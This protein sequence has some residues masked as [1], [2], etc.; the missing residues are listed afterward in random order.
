[1]CQESGTANGV[2]QEPS[3]KGYIRSYGHHDSYLAYR[4]IRKRSLWRKPNTQKTSREEACK[5][6]G[7][8]CKKSK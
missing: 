3:E 2:L 8:A 6:R 1:M 5:G 7:E 4:E